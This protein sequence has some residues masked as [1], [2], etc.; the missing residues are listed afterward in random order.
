LNSR[1]SKILK[2]IEEK[3]EK[4]FNWRMIFKVSRILKSYDK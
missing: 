1:N 2:Q 3:K 4:G